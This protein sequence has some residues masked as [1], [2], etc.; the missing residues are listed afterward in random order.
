MDGVLPSFGYLKSGID[1]DGRMSFKGRKRELDGLEV[2]ARWTSN[3]AINLYTFHS[4]I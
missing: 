2:D 4:N 3:K 1:L